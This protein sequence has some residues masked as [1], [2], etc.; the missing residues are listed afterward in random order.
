MSE[1]IIQLNEE[2]VFEVSL[3]ELLY[4]LVAVDIVSREPMLCCHK[5]QGRGEMGFA[6]ARRAKEYHIFSIF[7][8]AHGGQL[9]DLALVNGGL[10]REIEIIR[11]LKIQMKLCSDWTYIVKFV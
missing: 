4:Q 1:K 7:Q 8:E 5:A 2:T 11:G 10:E 9:V 3:L 6:Y